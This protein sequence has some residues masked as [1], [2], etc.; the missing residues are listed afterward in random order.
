ML[1]R[2]DKEEI[3]IFLCLQRFMQ[4]GRPFFLFEG[5]IKIAFYYFVIG[6]DDRFLKS[7][8]QEIILGILY[9]VLFNKWLGL[10]RMDNI[11]TISEQTAFVS[12]MFV[13]F[14][15]HDA[16][17][18]WVMHFLQENGSLSQKCMKTDNFRDSIHSW[19]IRSR[20]LLQHH[21]D[22]FMSTR[23]LLCTQEHVTLI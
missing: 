7:W 13:F 14:N 20:V 12:W 17:Y 6:F 3:T 16:S 23:T 15:P 19:H 11:F 4:S 18:F 2:S 1:F 8:P 21:V 10:S 22:L 5:K 9:L